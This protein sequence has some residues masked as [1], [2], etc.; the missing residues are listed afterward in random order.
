MKTS[1]VVPERMHRRG[2][3]AQRLAHQP[4][5]EA[6]QLVAHVALNLR[7]RHERRDGVDHH[8]VHSPRPHEHV[9]NLQGLLAVVGLRH[10]QLFHLHAQLAGVVDVEGVLGVDEGRHAA[11]LLRLGDGVQGERGLARALR[12]VHLDDA[13]PGKAADA[14]GDVQRDRARPDDLQVGLGLLRSVE[15]HDRAL[16]VLL[17]DPD[18]RQLK[19][20]L[21]IFV[22]VRLLPSTAPRRRSQ[23]P[24]AFR[25]GRS[26]RPAA[27]PTYAP[28][29][30]ARKVP[31]RP[32][33][34]YSVTVPALRPPGACA[35]GRGA[36]RLRG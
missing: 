19:G 34:T 4:R 18:Q 33:R 5:L 31:A 12:T 35:A 2:E 22:H 1:S 20:L 28:S 16:A 25:V 21:A 17:L 26:L 14:Q 23:P 24:T 11:E 6:R 10:Q 13:P 3:L 30:N 29:L 32:P 36:Q 15:A 8:D 9:G 7:L 27:P